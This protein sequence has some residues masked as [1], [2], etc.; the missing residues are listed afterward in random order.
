ML[1]LLFDFFAFVALPE[2]TIFV[3]LDPGICGRFLQTFEGPAGVLRIELNATVMTIQ[4][5]GNNGCS[6]AAKERVDD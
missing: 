5:A 3:T 4:L 1:F 2:D 6:S